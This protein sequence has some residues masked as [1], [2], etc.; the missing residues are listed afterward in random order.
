MGAI[1]TPL[2]VT[3]TNRAWNMVQQNIVQQR[4]PQDNNTLFIEF[5]AGV[6][7]VNSGTR[8]I[9][10][11]GTSPNSL[12]P[13][14]VLISRRHIKLCICSSPSIIP[15]YKRTSKNKCF[16][17]IPQ[18]PRLLQGIP[19]QCNKIRFYRRYRNG[20]TPRLKRYTH[21]R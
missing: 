19:R 4:T 21:A 14:L 2:E 5:G 15:Q 18:L 20:R 3:N 8:N 11:Y 7:T 6:S 9:E 13:F 10:F 17:S 12:L 16:I 1:N